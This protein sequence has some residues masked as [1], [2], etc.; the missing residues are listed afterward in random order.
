MSLRFR[1]GPFTFGRSGTRL[2]LWGR[3]AGISIPISG[4]K[5]RT[6]GKVKVGPFSWFFSESSSPLYSKLE[7][8]VKRE[9]LDSFIKNIIDSVRVDQEFI[10]NLRNNSIPW[11]GLQ[12][13]IKEDLPD[14]TIDK[15]EIAYLLVPKVLD[16]VFGKQNIKWKTEKR[17]S[18]ST[19]G[20]TTWIIII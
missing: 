6:F 9:N 12:E 8:Q 15:D 4:K 7:K 1:I 18:K 10:Q 13:R 16:V 5:N 20:F 11:R 17:P 19:N 14:D 2:S 3:G